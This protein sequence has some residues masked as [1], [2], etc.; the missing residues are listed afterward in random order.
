[1]AWIILNFNQKRG[2]YQLR[3]EDLESDETKIEEYHKLKVLKVEETDDKNQKGA[4]YNVILENGW[5]YR[6][7]SKNS[8]NN[9][10]GKKKEF[11]IT[12]HR[13]K[14]GSIKLDSEGQIK[15]SFRAVDSEKDW[16]AIKAKTEREIERSEKTVGQFI[17]ES[18]LENPKQ[19]IRGKLVKTIERKFYKNEIKKILEKQI[20]LQP[21]IFSEIA[22]EKCIEELYPRNEAHQ[23]KLKEKDFVHLFVEDIIF[24]QRPLKSQKSNISGCQYEYRVYNKINEET[25]IEEKVKQPLKVISKSHPLFQ[26]FRI[27]QWLHN[28]RIYKKEDKSDGKLI[29]DYDITNLLIK[30]DKDRAELFEF[31]TTKET[32]EQKHVID[33]FIKKKLIDKKEKEN[34]RWNYVEDKKYPC[35]ETR[36]TFSRR[37]NKVKGIDNATIFL[38]EKTQVGKKELSR[39]EQLWHIVYS[40]TDL[41]EFE[42]A[43]GKFAIKHN[44][45]KESFVNSFIK[46]PPFNS[47]YA[48][49]SKKA[50]DK[51]VP[52]MRLGKFWNES[53]ISPLVFDRYKAIKER[54]DYL[55]I[56]EKLSEKDLKTKLNEVSDD[57]IPKQ[58]IKSFLN[59]NENPLS[60]LNTYQ[61]CYL[62]YNRHSEIG[63]IQIWKKPDDIDKYLNNFRQHSLRNPIVE[64][65]VTETLRVVRDIW[66]YY[67]SSAQNFFNEIHVELGREMKNSSDKRKRISSKNNENENTNARIKEVLRE[68]MN[69]P[70]IEGDVR[71]YSPSHQEILK[72]YEEGITQNPDVKYDKMKEEEVEKIRKTSNPSQKDILRYILWLEQGYISPYTGEIIKL[73][74][75]F[76]S[77]YQIEHIIPQSRYFDNSFSNKV[78][79]ESAINPR[80]YK[81]NKTAFEFI[82]KMGGSIIPELSKKGKT[83]KLFTLEKYQ[84]HVNRYFKKNKTKLSNLLSE[85]IPEGFINRQMNDSRYISK[86]IKGLLSNIVRQEGEQEA[87]SK[88]LLPVTGSI[89]NKLKND[90]GL[91]DKWN[92]IIAPRFMRMNDLTNSENFGFWDKSI[93]AFRIQVPDEISK[94]FSKK[95][96]DHRHH[97]LDAL[98]VACI[99]RD[100]THYLSALNAEKENYSLKGKLLIKNKQGDY[101][102]NF[103]LPWNSFPV[104]AKNSLE[105]T[106]VSFKQNLRVIN[107]ATNKFWSYKDENGNFNIGKD[108]KLKKKLRKQT[109][110]ENWAIRKALHNPMPYGIVELDFDV[111][112][113]HK[114]IGK[115]DFIIDKFIKE[116]VEGIFIKNDKNIGR[117]SKYLKL[118]PIIHKNGSKIIKTHFKIKK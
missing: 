23:N 85:D 73:S 36:S 14:D 70:S 37:L 113:I 2:Y 24:Y 101:T 116:K 117:T 58:I 102:K 109:K 6:R 16:A 3:G 114:N 83:V 71:D 32:V 55:N 31:L 22:L 92:E 95:R 13:D 59:S 33:Y 103:Q 12:T 91:N 50:L 68:L 42:S 107:K 15:R 67:G 97:A 19:K 11:I 30:S 48:S 72:I 10:I 46:Y 57:D 29:V 27:W 17:Y 106:V 90:W 1:M 63:D 56:N 7:Q 20:E 9:W 35:Y 53:D 88:N 87:T 79:C 25:S 44:I 112:D 76:T 26:E 82:S 111:L 18:L 61:A 5:I 49:Y 105:K 64:Q 60:G 78:I 86:L 41:K 81:D 108:G 69:D 52:L 84:Q 34:Y 39:E 4:W 99:N 43:L 62:I 74:E 77:A 51:I 100:H 75:L 54:I 96:I 110:G 118:N 45:D 94:G 89:T 93:N 115:R 80:P 21:E 40:V 65:V 28:L 104:D 98:V 66:V 8:L 47:D 38:I